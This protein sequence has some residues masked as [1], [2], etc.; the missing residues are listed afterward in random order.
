MKDR[1]KLIIRITVTA[2]LFTAAWF[3]VPV[4]SQFTPEARLAVNSW[5]NSMSPRF[6]E[7]GFNLAKGDAMYPL[8][9][10]N[11]DE[12]LIVKDEAAGRNPHHLT[13]AFDNILALGI[14]LWLILLVYVVV[15]G[16]PKEKR[17]WFRSS[18]AS[19]AAL[20]LLFIALSVRAL[21]F[22][23][24]AATRGPQVIGDIDN[25]VRV[26]ILAFVFIP[27]MFVMP[28]IETKKQSTQKDEARA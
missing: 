28:R 21:V 1:T 27:M 26:V 13:F 4:P 20:S 6:A 7:A 23:A 16:N 11:G 22:G 25:P 17:T 24:I 9:K 5:M 14:R 8:C 12:L 2:V 19:A 15:F 3:F 10:V 18:V